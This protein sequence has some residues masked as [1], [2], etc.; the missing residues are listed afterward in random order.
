[1]FELTPFDRRRK[2]AALYNPFREFE[3][4][5]KR[6]FGE[7]Q[8]MEFKTDIKDKGDAYLLEAELPGVKKEDINVSIEDHYLTISAE[9]R[10]EKEEN[11]KEG[12]WIRC[13]RSYGSFSR[14]FDISSVD[15]SN[16]TAE[17]TDG[18]LKLNLPKQ[19]ETQPP[20]RRLEIK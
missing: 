3:E 1:M 18:V 19:A 5:E 8:P 16:I 13:E 7:T 9:R 10:S 2:N 4:M 11:D 12:G 15:A 14:S 17:Y 20:I 6:F